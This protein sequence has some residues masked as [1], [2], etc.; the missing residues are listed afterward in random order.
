MPRERS[1]VM[2]KHD[3][4]KLRDHAA[5]RAVEDAEPYR[6][7]SPKKRHADK[8]NGWAVV[9]VPA[10]GPRKLIMEGLDRATA[11]HMKQLLDNAWVAGRRSAMLE[12]E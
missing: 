10:V 4:E 5:R 1:V 12:A 7:Y 6:T 8:A 2:D 11:Q 3:P 9:H